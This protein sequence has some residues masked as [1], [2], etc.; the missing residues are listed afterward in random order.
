MVH[1]LPLGQRIAKRLTESKTVFTEYCTSGDI[2]RELNCLLKHGIENTAIC[3]H[4]TGLLYLHGGV[5]WPS[6]HSWG[7]K[8]RLKLALSI[9]HQYAES[10]I[11]GELETGDRFRKGSFDV[12]TCGVRQRQLLFWLRY[13]RIIW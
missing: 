8:Y 1:L 12:K 13:Q 9:A 11:T 5:V 6:E 2:V 10:N 3:H 4:L 7:I